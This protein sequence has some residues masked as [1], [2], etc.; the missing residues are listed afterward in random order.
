MKNQI[1]VHTHRHGIDVYPFKSKTDYSGWY[2]EEDLKGK[3]ILSLCEKLGV[4]LEEDRGD[5]KIDI[6]ITGE[7]IEV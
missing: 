5:E 7:F 3:T 1:L 2:Y 6:F 4:E